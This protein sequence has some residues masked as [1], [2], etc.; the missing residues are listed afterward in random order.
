MDKPYQ[1]LG[2]DCSPY[3]SKTR[4]Y[5][6]YKE[7]PHQDRYPTALQMKRVVEKRVGFVIMPV[8]IEP[9]GHVLQDSE[10]IIDTLEDRFKTRCINP[11]TPCQ[12]LVSKI[13]AL[14]ADEWMPLIAMHTRWNI[15]ENVSFIRRDFGRNMFPFLPSVLHPFIGDSIAKKMASYLPILGIT[16]RTQPAIEQWLKEL[17]AQL[18]LHLSEHRFLLGSKPCRGD[19]ALFGPLYAHVRRD[20]GSSHFVVQ[21]SNVDAW[22]DRMK[23]P[24]QSE[25]GE[26]LAHDQIPESLFGILRRIFKE[27]LPVLSKTVESVNQWCDENPGKAKLPRALGELEMQ[28][29]DVR[30]KRK[31]LSFAYWKFQKVLDL[32]QSFNDDDVKAVNHLLSLVDGPGSLQIHLRHKL[33][34]ENYRLVVE[35]NN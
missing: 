35:L 33:K 27:Q 31:N 4:A 20:P 2:W 10:V 6:R 16:S 34:M 5:F 28:I 22:I 19:F 25:E 11:T 18:D 9:N 24:Q 17:L 7:I 26:F 14:N 15:P 21:H 13:I 8:V 12:A 1:H 32:Y 3:S 29:G 23:Q 30:E